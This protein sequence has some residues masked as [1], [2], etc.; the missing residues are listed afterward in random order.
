[1]YKLIIVGA[2]TSGKSTLMRYLRQHTD[3][4]VAEMDE[5]IVK[6]NKGR[7]PTDDDY[8]NTVL[9][10]K[11]TEKIIGMDEVVYISSYVP[12]EL[13]KKAK[14]KGFKIALLEV[15]L[16]Q[17]KARNTKRMLEEKYETVAI[18]FDMQLSGFE[19]L[20][21]KD[22]IDKIIDGHKTTKEIADEILAIA[23]G[24]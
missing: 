14:R 10:P 20:K 17:L 4:V 5:E 18:Y 3:L 7:W 15:G 12:D 8:R 2:S 9:V 22:L 1:M 19:R 21:N 23:T 24:A 6:L 13:V 11:I 16:E